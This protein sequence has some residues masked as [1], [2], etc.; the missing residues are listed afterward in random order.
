[1]SATYLAQ[2]QCLTD[3]RFGFMDATICCKRKHYALMEK[4]NP[5]YG[6]SDKDRIRATART[7]GLQVPTKDKPNL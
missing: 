7:V 2:S 3:H 6:M 5:L 1:M 4:Y